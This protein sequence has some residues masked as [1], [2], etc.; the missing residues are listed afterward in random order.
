MTA[1]GHSRNPCN[2]AA[3]VLLYAADDN[4]PKFFKTANGVRVQEVI[5]GK[6]PQVQPGDAVL[7]DYVLRRSNGYFIYGEYQQHVFKLGLR[8]TD[9]VVGILAVVVPRTKHSRGTLELLCCSDM[10][11]SDASAGW[12]QHAYGDQAALM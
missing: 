3:V 5:V 7:I 8:S 6:G 4:L 9:V 2:E 10:P 1:I 11:F 12:R